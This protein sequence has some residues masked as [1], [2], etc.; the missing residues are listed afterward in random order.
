MKVIVTSRE[1]DDDSDWRA[2]YSVLVI[3]DTTQSIETS[4]HDGEPED[5]MLF[6]DFNDVYKIPDIIKAAHEAGL[7]GETLE[8]E[9][10]TEE[11]G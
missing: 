3:G 4:F 8:F 2:A 7:R 10:R 5:A 1:G 9:E 6:R 11:D